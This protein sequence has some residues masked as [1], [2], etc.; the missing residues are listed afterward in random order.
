MEVVP[1]AG[2]WIEID[3]LRLTKKTH[4][5]VPHAGTWIEIKLYSLL[6]ETYHVVPHAG[7][8]IEIHDNRIVKV[9]ESASFPTRERGLKFMRQIGAVEVGRRSP[10]GNVD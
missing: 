5:V 7:T 6:M 8:W 1:H 9:E 3:I 10:R 4:T 2:T